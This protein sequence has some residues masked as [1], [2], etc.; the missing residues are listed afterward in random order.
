MYCLHPINVRKWKEV[1][2]PVKEGS[3]IVRYE[4][5]NVRSNEYHYV[6]C[7]KCVACL[8]RKRNE[9][10]YRLKQ[11][12]NYSS[13][14]W[15]LTLTYDQENIPI[16]I[17][18]DTPYFVF[19][20]KDVQDYMKRVR[21]YFSEVNKELKLS[22][23]LVSEYGAHTYRPHY[24]MLLFV[25]NDNDMQYKH[26]LEKVLHD[27]WKCGFTVVKPTNDANIHYCTKYC[28][29]NLEELPEQCIEP[30]FVLASKRPY[31]G[32]AA[33][34]T[35][36]RQFEDYEGTQQRDT[37]VFNNGCKTAMPRIYRQKLGLAGLPNVMS[38]YDPRLTQEQYNV[39][40]KDLSKNFTPGTP[41]F[42]RHLANRVNKQF[43]LLERAARARQL[44]R[45][46][47]F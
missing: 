15:F 23:F 19:N 3:K 9:F 27:Q 12:Q 25:K 10:T 47:S 39:Y 1:R 37:V 30:V 26:V 43:N 28:I 17:R 36:D 41:E 45:S 42:S 4:L 11:E 14:S 24:H 40:A 18:D 2:S 32:S 16:K 33:E 22:Y 8:S 13:Y 46:E 38:D 20:K 35:I 34:G 44:S 21:Y 31:L 29:K 7:G 5:K 6:P